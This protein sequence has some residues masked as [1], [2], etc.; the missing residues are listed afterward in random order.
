[1]SL[2][3]YRISIHSFVFVVSNVVSCN[4]GYQKTAGRSSVCASQCKRPYVYVCVCV[5][6]CACVCVCVCVCVGGWVGEVGRLIIYAC[7]R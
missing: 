3:D 2:C 6:V 4:K 1:M 7:G 5:C